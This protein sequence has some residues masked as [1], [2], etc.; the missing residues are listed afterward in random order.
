MLTELLTPEEEEEPQPGRGPEPQPEP[1]PEAENGVLCG[2]D[3]YLFGPRLEYSKL[4]LEEEAEAEA[5]L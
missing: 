5:G 1:E 2:F 4:E 3:K